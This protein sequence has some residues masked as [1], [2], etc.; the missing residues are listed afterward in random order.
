MKPTDY[1][2]PKYPSGCSHKEVWINKEKT[3]TYCVKCG[4]VREIK[5]EAVSFYLVNGVNYL[6]I[7]NKG[8]KYG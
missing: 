6:N 8:V 7:V 3:K 4:R 1:I 5:P 2:I